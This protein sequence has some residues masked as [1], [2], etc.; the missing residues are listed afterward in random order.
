LLKK[1]E[2]SLNELK[3]AGDSFALRAEE[4]AAHMKASLNTSE[5]YG[6]ELKG[7]AGDIAKASEQSVDQLN[8]SIKGLKTQMHD[9]GDAANDVTAMVE[10]SRN[11]L[12]D[13]SDRLISVSTAALESAKN[14]ALTFGKQSEALFKASKDASGFAEK[15]HDKTLRVQRDGFMNAAKF[16][17]ESLHSLSV[18][19]TRMKDGEISEKTWK[20]FQKGDVAAFTRRLASISEDKIAMDKARNKFANDSEFRTYVQRYIRQFE[21]VYTSAKDNDH[22]SMLSA[23]IGSSEVGRLYE[24]LISLTEKK[25][26]LGQSKTKAA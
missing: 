11:K 5:K 15:M 18:D 24:I 22:G 9:I 20:A 1:S 23:T 7:Q 8:K 17:V 13:E 6:R 12:G 26:V 2:T 16:I 14:A 25:S 3:K 21:E 19:L 4:V 10:Q